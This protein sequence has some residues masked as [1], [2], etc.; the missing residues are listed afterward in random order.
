MLP[1]MSAS[2]GLGPGGQAPLSFF[3]PEPSLAVGSDPLAPAR[4]LRQLVAGLHAADLSVIMQVSTCM[5]LD[6]LSPCDAVSA[7]CLQ[8]CCI[9]SLPVWPAWTQT[10]FYHLLYPK[11][12]NSL[13]MCMLQ[14]QYCFTAE[15][16]SDSRKPSSLLGLDGDIYYRC[17]SDTSCCWCF[18]STARTYW[19]SLCKSQP[20]TVPD[21]SECPY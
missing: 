17:S 21:L 6:S 20:A 9:H 16:Q 11:L 15:G 13:C 19:T 4:E 10:I 18:H 5:C 1:S 8:C 12:H 2:A 7:S 3:A 14:V